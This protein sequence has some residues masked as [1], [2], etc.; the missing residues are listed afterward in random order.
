[1]E[2]YEVLIPFNNYNDKRYRLAKNKNSVI[3]HDSSL[4]VKIN[5]QFND[6]LGDN[7]TIRLPDMY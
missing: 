7:M 6:N 1:M 2:I 4:L 3:S 5:C